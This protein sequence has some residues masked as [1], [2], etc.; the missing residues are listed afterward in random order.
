MYKTHVKNSKG[1]FDLRI[2]R[3]KGV[4]DKFLSRVA[5]NIEQRDDGC[6]I[7]IGH[8]NNRGYGVTSVGGHP[9]LA[10]RVFYMV[11]N[12]VALT[13][14]DHICHT[15]HNPACVN[16]EHLYVGNA[17]TNGSDRRKRFVK[18]DPDCLPKEDA[19]EIRARSNRGEKEASIGLDFDLSP[20][21]V[22][23]VVVK[24][25]WPWLK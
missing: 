17:K 23:M 14:E 10:H 20:A 16:P 18:F 2:P 5:K 21:Q 19:L 4:D 7:W 22:R 8:K 9:M 15:C 11:A 12:R 3:I 25:D 24:Y 1:F 13:R 6:I